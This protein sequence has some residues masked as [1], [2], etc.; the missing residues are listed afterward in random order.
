MSLP[1][2]TLSDITAPQNRILREINLSHSC[3]RLA[4]CYIEGEGNYLQRHTRLGSWAH[5]AK[6]IVV[7]CELEGPFPKSVQFNVHGEVIED[8]YAPY[9]AHLTPPACDVPLH[10]TVSAHLGYGAPCFHTHFTIQGPSCDY[11][12]CN[13]E[14]PPNKHPVVPGSCIDD[15]WK[16]CEC[17]YGPPQC[18]PNSLPVSDACFSSDP[19]QDCDC[20]PGYVW[21]GYECVP[22]CGNCPAGSRPKYYDDTCVHSFA[23]CVCNAGYERHDTYCAERPLCYSHYAC[24]NHSYA[25][26]QCVHSFADCHC[27]EG[28]QR[29][30]GY[31]A[32][33]Q[34]NHF[35][36]AW[37]WYCK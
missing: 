22:E 26:Q 27:K 25:T 23:D 14:C 35:T 16:D 8:Y 5:D 15:V 33:C 11:V 18:P 13:R 17:D 1:Y 10:F 12:P 31:C 37:H 9:T 28:Y 21:K 20:R 30:A 19:L 2:S 3:P 4:G 32:P 34:H 7:H 29:R 36:G 6:N 24:P